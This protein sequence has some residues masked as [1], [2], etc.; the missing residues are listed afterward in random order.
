MADKPV[1]KR[2]AITAQ[3]GTTINIDF[4]AELTMD[5]ESETPLLA[6]VSK[7]KTAKVATYN[8]KF[9]VDRFI[10]RTGTNT[11]AAAATSTNGAQTVTLTAA[12][13][14]YF[15][16]YDVIELV[17]TAED[18]T[19][20][21]Q[22]FVT[23]ATVGGTTL[24]VYPFDPTLGVVAITVGT[25][26]RR[27]FS[28]MVEGSSGRTSHQTVPTVYS[29]YIQIFEDYFDVTNV[30]AENRQYTIPERARLRED[31]RKKHA[32][33]QEY[34]FFLSKAM[35]S[36]YFDSTNV[37]GYNRYQMSGIKDQISTN[38]M[39]YG[40]KLDQDEFFNFI[41][42]IH[43]PAYTGGNKRLVFSSGTFLGSVNKLATP[44]LRISTRESTWGVDIS[45]VQFAGKVWSFVEAPVLSEA[46]DGDA[47]VLHPMF[48]RKRNFLPTTYKMNV[49]NPIDNF[50]RD[51]FI[52]SCAIEQRLEEVAGWI[53]R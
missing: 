49:Q 25:V 36:P 26:V 52:T 28:S 30:Q 34:A 18:S 51:G 16:I 6:L 42:Q 10:P 43:N 2:A 17:G 50:F 23:A 46:R 48:L 31:T 24:T 7:L 5:H 15:N 39:G 53:T 21:A 11:V 32:L 41:T 33:D 4:S 22:C 8:Y 1:V 14:T 35:A 38:T 37:S 12:D 20:T 45:D 44:S 47:A 19:H 3:T 9:A 27:L 40:D 29:Q 13:A